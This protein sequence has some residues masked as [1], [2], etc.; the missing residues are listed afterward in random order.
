M[1]AAGAG[2]G[3][4]CHD[5]HHDRLAIVPE[6]VEH[7]LAGLVVG[8]GGHGADMHLASHP[9]G[10]LDGEADIVDLRDDALLHED[11]RVDDLRED[12]EVHAVAEALDRVLHAVCV[13]DPDHADAR[14]AH[15]GKDSEVLGLPEFIEDD[16]VR[17]HEQEHVGGVGHA[18]VEHRVLGDLVGHLQFAGGFHGLDHVAAVGEEGCERSGRGWSCLSREHRR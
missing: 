14:E 6:D 7:E 10:D 15:V 18:A 2:R 9:L 17:A 13:D 1:P 4:C 12:R 3:G 16:E 8:D 11:D 5:R